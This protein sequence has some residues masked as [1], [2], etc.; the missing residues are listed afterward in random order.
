M[1]KANKYYFH[2]IYVYIDVYILQPLFIYNVASRTGSNS[3]TDVR[4]SICHNDDNTKKSVD[5][6]SWRSIFV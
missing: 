4:P 3:V 1:A 6:L 5:F 2:T